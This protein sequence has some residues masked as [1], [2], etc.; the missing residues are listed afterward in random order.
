[1]VEEALQLRR[2]TAES[3]EALTSEPTQVRD[4][5]R[6][7]VEHLLLDDSIAELLRIQLGSVGRQPFE[8]VVVGVRR[9]KRLHR[10]GPV[11]VES[12]PD[13]DQR[14]AQL[15]SE[16]PQ[17]D[18]DLRSVNGPGEVER[19]ETGWPPERG[20]QGRNAGDLPSL[21][22]PPQEG[23]LPSWGP[24]GAYAG[25]KR[26]TRLVHEGNRTPCA[27][28]PFFIRGQ[29]RFNQAST[30]ASSR[31]LAWSRGRWGLQP[32]ARSASPSPRKW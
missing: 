17:R 32:C 6:L 1:V 13:D 11:G 22:D 15:A 18:D 14:A 25:P 30:K 4:R 31:S 23:R 16:I 20:D 12:I 29:S 8:L 24:G 26:V 7:S 2:A 27:A 9:H 21:T 5:L 19:I 3:P 28:S 10:F